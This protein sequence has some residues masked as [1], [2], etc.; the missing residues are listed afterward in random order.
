MR[1]GAARYSEGR[2]DAAVIHDSEVQCAEMGV[3]CGATIEIW[4]SDIDAIAQKEYIQTTRKASQAL[5]TEYD[6]VHG[7]V[8]LR[9][10]GQVKPSR[11]KAYATAFTA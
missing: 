3:D 7:S 11:A 2:T 5:G 10:T 6:T 4:P 8:L 9:V 1:G